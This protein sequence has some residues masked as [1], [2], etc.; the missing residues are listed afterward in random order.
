MMVPKV[1]A[2]P[3]AIL[4]FKLF[5][6]RRG[7]TTLEDTAMNALKQIEEKQYEAAL[8]SRGIP[9]DKILKY[10]FAFKEKECLIRKG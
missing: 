9:K 10:G 6:P 7:E 2:Y 8:L 4:E 3:A 5:N 1:S